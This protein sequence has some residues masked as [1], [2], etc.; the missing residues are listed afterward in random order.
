M[1]L[2]AMAIAT[3][4]SI[5]M[6]TVAGFDAMSDV[7]GYTE[8]AWLGLIV[9]GMFVSY[10][11]FTASYR[12]T[13][14]PRTAE[15]M[16]ENLAFK[17]VAFGAAATLR[18]GYS[19][20]RRAMRA[21]GASRTDAAVRVT[22]LAAME[23]AVLALAAW[24]SALLLLD[25]P[26]V[27]AAVSVPWAIGVPAG[28]A[29]AVA[30]SLLARPRLRAR[31]GPLAQLQET[32]VGA[33]ELIRAQALHPWRHRRAWGGMVLHWGGDLA[34]MWAALRAV[35]L[36]PSASV[37]ILGYATGYAL[38]PRSLPLAGVGVT[39]A[40]M[41]LSLKWVGLPLAPSVLAVWMYR[42]SRLLAAVPPALIARA[43]VQRL[44]RQTP[45]T[46]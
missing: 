34:A 2:V 7:I 41:P 40:L 43:E 39:E 25:D 27:K 42:M 35:G 30:F 36:E 4:V 8:P 10:A 38:S 5:A 37:L 11:G 32:L 18:S 23:M 45:P 22:T 6:G 3:G 19:V 46:G 20:D 14:D 28:V 12:G 29:L 33:L 21:V 26:H 24:V 44:L 13:L 16:P 1:A 17:L 15:A 31:H 9:A